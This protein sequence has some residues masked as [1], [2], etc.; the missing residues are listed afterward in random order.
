[1]N[2][3]KQGFVF[4]DTLTLTIP[5]ADNTKWKELVDI[6]QHQ[7]ILIFLDNNGDYWCM[8][9]RHGAN[10]DGYKRENNEYILEFNAI[11]ESKILTNIDK[12]YVIDSIL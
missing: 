11:S 7:Y 8:G 12:Q 6:L 10:V 1:M 2:K 9:Y 4:T 5:E 3:T